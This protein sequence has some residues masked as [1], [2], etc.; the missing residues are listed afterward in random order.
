MVPCSICLSHMTYFTYRDAL[1]VYPC[2]HMRRE[3]GLISF[4]FTHAQ[5][6][7]PFLVFSS[8][9]ALLDSTSILPRHS[10]TASTLAK[11]KLMDNQVQKKTCNQKR[12]L[13]FICLS[14]KIHM[15]MMFQSSVVTFLSAQW[16]FLTVPCSFLQRRLFMQSTLI[17]CQKYPHLLIKLIISC[18]SRYTYS[19]KKTL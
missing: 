5:V 1:Q 15:Y 4:L 10:S 3:N 2:C 11:L 9:E 7:W 13:T 19:G 12:A 8:W 6:E 16:C 17:H 14:F 18:F